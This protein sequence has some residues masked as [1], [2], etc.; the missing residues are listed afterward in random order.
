MEKI[1]CRIRY[2]VVWTLRKEGRRRGERMMKEEAS[3]TAASLARL[4]TTGDLGSSAANQRAG[5][6]G[7][8]GH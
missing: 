2:S 3:E 5:Q 8:V 7:V 4:P 1:V 6:A